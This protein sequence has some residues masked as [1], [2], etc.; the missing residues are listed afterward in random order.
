[1]DQKK[2]DKLANFYTKDELK[3]ILKELG[4]PISGNKDTLCHR[5]NEHQKN[6]QSPEKIYIKVIP[7]KD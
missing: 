3:Q 7:R 4:L 5:I 6:H 2:E 1:M